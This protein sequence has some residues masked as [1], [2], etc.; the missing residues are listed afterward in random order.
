MNLDKAVF[1]NGKDLY[2]HLDKRINGKPKMKHQ[3]WVWM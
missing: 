1:Y 2:E 3:F